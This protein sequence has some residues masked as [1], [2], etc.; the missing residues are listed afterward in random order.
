MEAR[1]MARDRR[2]VKSIFDEAAEIAS[3][4]TIACGAPRGRK[5][6]R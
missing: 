4:R 2:G 5:S 3:P 1:I 6:A